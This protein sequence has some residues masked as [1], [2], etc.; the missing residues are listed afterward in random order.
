MRHAWVLAALI[1]LSFL[2]AAGTAH[3]IPAFGRRYGVPCATCHTAIPRR[4]EFGDAFRKAGYRWPGLVDEN[5]GVPPIEMRGVSA[6]RTLLPAHVP[7]AITS[8]LGAAYT[9]DPEV[10]DP[11]TLGRPAL[12]VLF[13]ASLGEHVSTFGNSST[14]G[15]LEELVLQFA[16]PW[17]RPELNLR[18]GLIEQS[19]TMFKSNEA[20][21]ARFPTG[22]SALS[23]HAISKSRMGGELNGVIASRIFW[24]TGVVQNAGAGSHLDLYYHLSTKIGGMDFLGN[25]PDIDLRDEKVIQDLSLTLAHWGYVGQ[26]ETAIGEPVSSIR[27]YGFE[28]RI[29]FHDVSLLGGAMVGNDR[30]LVTYVDDLSLTW[31]GEL[32]YPIWTWLTP[33]YMYQYQDAESFLHETQRHDFGLI[34]LPLENVR[35]RAR[36]GYTDDDTENEEAELQIFLAL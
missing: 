8:T 5:A 2:A 33:T 6:G 35:V 12:S 16:R 1:G 21:L 13:G 18:L 26:V 22:S 32:S 23:G 24:A 27:R 15:K 14:D 36:V 31:F 34:F 17:G 19:T 11:V 4:N 29:M 30:D 25:E 10:D 9:N 7:I 28:T 3:A 20:L